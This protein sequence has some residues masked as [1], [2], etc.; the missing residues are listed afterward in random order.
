[1]MTEERDQ[2]L[3]LARAA[4]GKLA[5][6]NW[7]PLCSDVLE[8]KAGKAKAWETVVALPGKQFFPCTDPA[9]DST[10]STTGMGWATDEYLVRAYAA[11]LMEAPEYRPPTSDLSENYGF[12]AA[13][14]KEVRFCRVCG[15]WMIEGRKSDHVKSVQHKAKMRQ[16]A[17]V[18]KDTA[19]AGVYKKLRPLIDLSESVRVKLEQ[20]KVRSLVE[21]PAGVRAKFEKEKAVKKKPI[22]KKRQT[23]SHPKNMGGT[24]KIIGKKK[25]YVSAPKRLTATNR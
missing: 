7:A 3:E 10:D 23:A 4:E 9:L 24:R 17:D 13:S 14:K 5:A 1:M 15:S 6:I 22:A 19:V 18:E 2:A 11:Y 16:A 12:P 20:K 25:R 8:I 21:I